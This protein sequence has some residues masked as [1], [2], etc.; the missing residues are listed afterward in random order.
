MSSIRFFRRWRAL[1]YIP[2]P[3]RTAHSKRQV[4]S[5]QTKRQLCGF[6]F[7]AR[8]LL[9]PLDRNAESSAFQTL[10]IQDVAA[11]IPVQNPYLIQATIEKDKQMTAE[12]IELQL[13]L[14]VQTEAIK[15]LARVDGIGR[16]IHPNRGRQA[17]HPDT[18][19]EHSARAKDSG[20]CAEN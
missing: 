19:T 10:C 17:Q 11:A 2:F 12:W 3:A 14:N 4:N 18:S 8:T 7:S 13:R 9:C 16:D 5:L 6:N 1:L 15:S 20:I